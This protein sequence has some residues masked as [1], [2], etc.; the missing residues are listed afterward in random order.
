MLTDFQ[1]IF[2]GRFLGKFAE[3][4]LEETE[5]LTINYK[6]SVATYIRCGEVLNGF[7]ITKLWVYC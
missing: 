3:K 4:L 2:S 7:L 5:L 1:N 6:V